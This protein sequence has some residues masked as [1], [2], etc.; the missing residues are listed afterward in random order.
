MHACT[1]CVC[2]CA[3]PSFSVSV[4]LSRST[5]CLS[6]VSTANA[7]THADARALRELRG[8][9]IATLTMAPLGKKE[10]LRWAA[11]ASGIRPCEKYADLR[12]GVVLLALA[13][14]LFPT[15]IDPQLVRL[16]PVDVARN[17]EALQRIMKRHG[18]PLHLCDRQSVAAGHARHCFNLLVLFYFLTRLA[19]D[20]EFCVDFANPIDADVAA[21]LQS[22]RSLRCV[23][24]LPARCDEPAQAPGA[25]DETPGTAMKSLRGRSLPTPQSPPPSSSA[26]S[27]PPAD[28]AATAASDDDTTTCLPPA[29]LST[30]SAKNSSDTDAHVRRGRDGD[31]APTLQ[32]LRL[33]N[34]RLREELE[35]VRA[36]SQLVLAQHRALLVGEVARTTEQFEVRLALLRLERDHEVRQCLLDVRE[37]YDGFLRTAR[38][39]ASLGTSVTAAAS[40]A[41]AS[42]SAVLRVAYR[43][44]EGKVHTYAQELA[45]ARDTVQQLR[46]ALQLQRDRHEA[47]TER[48]C[49]ICTTASAV[50][51]VADEDRLVQV[52]DEMLE[53]QPQ[54]MREAVALR[55][56]TLLLQAQAQAQSQAEGGSQ[57]QS[58]TLVEEEVVPTAYCGTDG[59]GVLSVKDEVRHLRTQIERLRQANHFLRQQQLP[60]HPDW[61]AV[62]SADTLESLSCTIEADTCD[63]ICARA[64]AVA[65]AHTPVESPVRQE[66]RRLV[67]VVR[68]LQARVQTATDALLVYKD[69]QQGLHEQLLCLQQRCKAEAH[70]QARASEARLEELQ[71]RQEAREAALAA[72]LS[73]V[74]ERCQRR[75]SVAATLHERVR[76][77]VGAA[78]QQAPS[79][80]GA[81]ATATVTTEALQRVLADVTDSQRTR[82]ALEAA[83]SELSSEVA[84]LR[85]DL[86]RRELAVASLQASLAAAEAAG[87]EA[88]AAAAQR[89][90]EV[91]AL[92]ET[93]AVEVDACRRYIQHVEELLVTTTTLPMPPTPVMMGGSPPAPLPSLTG[94]AATTAK[95]TIPG[96]EGS[97]DDHSHPSDATAAAMAAAAS[98]ASS[99]RRA[100]TGTTPSLLSTEELERRK[101]AILGKYGFATRL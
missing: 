80:T 98:A 9:A 3:S 7:C 83:L 76:E 87:Q 55:L 77:I 16:G 54:A 90:A 29:A 51:A 11:E 43:A 12:D 56:R 70:E 79:H 46:N 91:N 36:T 50:G 62:P 65:E 18:L 52:I 44:L 31:G 85:H 100:D 40:A 33:A 17:W 66:L 96:V 81:A 25:G 95:T 75:E 24:K 10:L 61:Y 8:W 99:A 21:F 47:L 41:D 49:R 2:V 93:A 97:D 92:R 67:L 64:S 27:S 69:K 6:A 15:S 4:C 22:P 60:P 84:V 20:S 13:G 28:A 71:L 82:D 23:G 78:L 5:T 26:T 48:I 58:E 19:K 68:I 72:K 94:L 1:L 59:G 57:Q 30:L 86:A 101:R 88:R 39:E 14:R 53:T 34:V 45:E 74:E 37:A 35:H 38:E 63:T 89:T 73:L 32:S 42:P